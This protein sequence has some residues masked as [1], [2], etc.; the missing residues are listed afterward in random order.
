MG[1]MVEDGGGGGELLILRESKLSVK[2]GTVWVPQGPGR[3]CLLAEPMDV[4]MGVDLQALHLTR[5]RGKRGVVIPTL[6]LLWLFFPP[7]R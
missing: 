3:A 1:E 4:G 2:S 6:A 5:G 7:P